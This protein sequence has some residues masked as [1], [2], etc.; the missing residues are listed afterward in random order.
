[1]MRNVRTQLETTKQF[2]WTNHKM[3]SMNKERAKMV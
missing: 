1:M 2:K 3:I